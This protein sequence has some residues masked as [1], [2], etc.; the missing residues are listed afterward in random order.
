MQHEL[1]LEADANSMSKFEKPEKP[2]AWHTAFYYLAEHVRHLTG[3]EVNH[4]MLYALVGTKARYINHPNPTVR[5]RTAA[6]LSRT[7]HST[8]YAEG[9]CKRY[10]QDNTAFDDAAE[11]IYACTAKAGI[12]S[13]D[14]LSTYLAA[15]CWPDV[16]EGLKNERMGLRP[17]IDLQ[18]A[19]RESELVF[20]NRSKAGA[21]KLSP[22]MQLAA[23]FHLISFGFLDE[24]CAQVLVGATGKLKPITPASGNPVAE[25]CLGA[26]LVRF[27]N[28]GAKTVAGFWVLPTE[29]PFVIGRFTDCDSVESDMAI[30]RRHASVRFEGDFWTFEDLNSKNGSAILRSDRVIATSDSRENPFPIRLEYGDTIVLAGTSRYW[31][32]PFCD[33]A[34]LM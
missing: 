22:Q 31:F 1:Q 29:R 32:G 21:G 10:M 18:R 4:K 25:D 17:S 24:S 6:R 15:E 33:N 30:S 13:A 14:D 7:V 3:G 26:C 11:K 9:M 28:D 12:V 8:A 20:G 34:P 16:F 23:L 27:S 2:R 19:L 5:K